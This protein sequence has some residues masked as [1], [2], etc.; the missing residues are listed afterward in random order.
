[1]NQ[2]QTK[3]KHFLERINFL[4]IKAEEIT[5]YKFLFPALAIFGL[6]SLYPVFY[7]LRLSFFEWDGFSP[8]MDFV[9]LQNYMQLFQDEILHKAIFNTGYFVIF[10]VILQTFL[11]LGT[12]VLIEKIKF[13]K[14]RTFF[15]TSYVFPALIA[16]SIVA[17]IFSWMFHPH[18]G[19][20]NNLLNTSIQWLG[21]KNTVMPAIIVTNM[22]KWIGW[23][24]LIFCAGIQSIDMDLYEAAEIDGANVWQ[25]FMFVTV[26]QLRSI[27]TIVVVT[28][29]I[30]GLKVFD[31]VW[32]MTA[33]GP[34]HASEVVTTWLYK[35]AFS[36]A[37]LGYASAIGYA[38][39]FVTFIF[40]YIYIQHQRKSN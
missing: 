40:S 29:M 39:T 15:R 1:M 31:L 24:A 12:A 36:K 35:Q 6:V 14:G 34:N 16:N 22:W 13:S 30:N 25:K 38:L 27:F 9:G 37:N 23:N 32:V 2:P 28:T 11:A 26:P 10:T 17:L 5:A 33:G 4:N 19:A 20:I 7:S 18:N 8:N 3:Q 21:N